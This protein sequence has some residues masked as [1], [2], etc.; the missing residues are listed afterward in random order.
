MY[1]DDIIVTG[2]SSS[3]VSSVI[4]S[5]C[6]TFESRRL[7]DLSYLLGIEATRKGD[8]LKLCQT[9]YAIDLLERFNMTMCKPSSTPSAPNSRLSLHDGDLLDDPTVSRSMVGGLQYLTLTRPD[10][11]FSVNQVCQFMH[12]P[13][14]SHFQA[15]KR[16]MR[17]VKGTLQSGL[18]FYPSTRFQIRAFSD[19]DWAGDPDDRRSTTGA[20]IFVG[21]NLVSWTA[22]KQSTLSRSSSE[23]E[24]RAL[25][26]TTAELR[27]FSYFFRELN[28]FLHPPSLFCENLSALHMARN[29]VFHART[30]H[31]EIDYHF[32]RELGTRS[33]LKTRFEEAL[34]VRNERFQTN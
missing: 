6:E 13:R 17:F 16:I 10:I 15:A 4:D 32:I 29:P 30:R 12:Q 21:S 18:T 11:A 24:Y 8:T 26:T 25:A 27:W 5:I 19:S 2:S 31:I 23:A 20:C 28:I 9:R 3:V 22:K 14:T 33:S 1:V 34:T 7:G